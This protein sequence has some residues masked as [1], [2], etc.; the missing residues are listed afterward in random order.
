MADD[1]LV[2][3]I[4]RRA[5]EVRERIEAARARGGHAAPPVTLVAVTKGHDAGTVRA[6][7]A[8][9]LHDIGEARVQEAR[10]K[11]DALDAAAPGRL[12]WHLIGQLQ[13]NKARAAAGLFDVVHSLDGERAAAALARGR[14]DAPPLPVLIEV[15][16][17]G[18]PGRGGVPP[19]AVAALLAAARAHPQLAVAGLMTVAAPGPAGQARAT[20]A[21]LRE[22]RDGLERAEGLRLAHLSMGMSDD[23][24]VAVE[25][26]A[27]L[28]RLGRTLFGPRPPI[29]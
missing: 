25:E 5:G 15:E 20:F 2:D 18:I 8:A 12:R 16:L 22:L 27:T 28:V 7:V 9:G 24:E 23:Y 1:A 13:S 3:V 19:G 11:H 21:R 17:T 14:G 26:G 29:S 6:A 10:G 4:R